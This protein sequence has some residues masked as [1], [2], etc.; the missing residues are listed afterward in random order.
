MPD[1]FSK[2]CEGCGKTSL[3][4][5]VPCISGLALLAPAH[6]ITALHLQSCDNQNHLHKFLNL[7]QWLVPSVLRTTVLA[8]L[9]LL[10]C[11]SPAA[12][13]FSHSA[14]ALNMLLPFPSFETLP[15]SGAQMV[16]IPCCFPSGT[17][18][19]SLK[20]CSTPPPTLQFLKH[21]APC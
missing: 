3:C 11:P 5:T 8:K 14:F 12:Y 15:T 17:R 16:Y 4:R 1:G 20:P 21:I 9:F 6:R 13:L 19:V 2:S 18:S 7:Y 10:S